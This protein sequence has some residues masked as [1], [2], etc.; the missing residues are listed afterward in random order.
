MIL[1]ILLAEDACLTMLSYLYFLY[2]HLLSVM[3]E[4]LKVCLNLCGNG[5]KFGILLTAG[6]ACLLV[7]YPFG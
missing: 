5:D 3:I 2:L 1:F 4:V 7:I 6:D